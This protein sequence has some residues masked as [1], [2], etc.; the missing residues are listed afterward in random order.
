M[1]VLYAE[2]ERQLSV[3]VTEILKME[4]FEVTPV[5]DGQE[6]LDAL[7]K[8]YFDVVVLDIMMPKKDGIEVL[9]AM[10][11]SGNYTA[12]LMLTAKATVDDRITGLSSG[13]DDYLAKPFAMKE[14]VARLNSLIRRNSSYRHSTVKLSNIELDSNTCELKSDKGSLRLN[15]PEAEVLTFL[16]RHVGEVFSAVQI[17]EQVWQGKESPEKAELYVFYLK[18]KLRQIH[19]KVNVQIESDTYRLCE[20]TL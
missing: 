14:L 1:K 8:D 2:D 16:I 19:S 7:G 17:N 15:N 4:G 12:V 18:N 11:S 13:A 5:Y 10:R 9:E 6:A 3:A 20:E